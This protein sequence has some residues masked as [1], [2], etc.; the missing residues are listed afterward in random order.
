MK[1]PNSIIEVDCFA[2]KK[3][4]TEITGTLSMSF[5]YTGAFV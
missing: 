4:R 3:Y 5:L 1:P 2:Q